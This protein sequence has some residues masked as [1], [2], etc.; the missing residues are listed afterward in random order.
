LSEHKCCGFKPD[1]SPCQRTVKA[2]F[3]YCYSHDPNTLEE[4]RRH[5]SRAGKGNSQKELRQLRAKLHDLLD[6]VL[7]GNIDRSVAAVA[8][9]VSN[10]LSR[11]YSVSL[12]AREVEEIAERLGE[13]EDALERR[14]KEQTGYGYTR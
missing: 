8:A 2:S 7:E 9:N 10:A 11:V 12:K 13:L 4:R 6:D 3:T 1:G 5:N 14:G